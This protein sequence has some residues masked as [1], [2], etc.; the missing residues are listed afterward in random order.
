M[1]QRDLKPDVYWGSVR[2]LPREK[3]VYSLAK[4]NL[5]L[6][7]AYKD[8]L[9]VVVKSGALKHLFRLTYPV[10]DNSPNR[11][12]DSALDSIHEI[13]GRALLHD[14]YGPAF[15]KQLGD[16]FGRFGRRDGGVAKWQFNPEQLFARVLEARRWHNDLMAL[17]DVSNTPEPAPV[18][19][20]YYYP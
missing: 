19:A 5:L 17:M 1:R 7:R 12:V 14:A 15:A 2:S 20:I 3:N 10:R 18:Q 11:T 16:S 13:F 4:G 9:T 6:L 8:G